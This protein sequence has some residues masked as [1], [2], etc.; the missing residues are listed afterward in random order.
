MLA[1][2]SC[3]RQVRDLFT[4]PFLKISCSQK[5]KFRVSHCFATRYG[6]SHTTS[7]DKYIDTSNQNL[8][9]KFGGEPMREWRESKSANTANPQTPGKGYSTAP[10][11]IVQNSHNLWGTTYDAVIPAAGVH[12][13]Y[14]RPH[15]MVIFSHMVD[16]HSPNSHSL[17]SI[18]SDS[19]GKCSKL[20]LWVRVMCNF[21]WFFGWTGSH[22]HQLTVGGP[23]TCLKAK[24]K[25]TERFQDC[26][27]FAISN[28]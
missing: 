23:S 21:F 26:A 16:L 10:S 24:L 13:H 27:T 28:K 4:S 7:I 1:T 3:C 9:T 5:H 19:S 6:A 20:W 11:I 15:S 2:L 18:H 14:S 25:W 12:P 22:I 8:L 17:S